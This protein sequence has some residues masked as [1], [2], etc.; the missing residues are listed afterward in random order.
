ARR[1]CT[2]A[3]DQRGRYLHGDLDGGFRYARIDPRSQK[4]VS[5]MTFAQSTGSTKAL[6]TLTG[7]RFASFVLCTFL[8]SVSAARA[9][10]AA[11]FDAAAV[12]RA[13]ADFVERMV[14]KHGFERAEVAATLAD[15]TIS[16][17][18]LE[19]IARPAE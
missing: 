6:H 18:I 9:D 10:D 11:G 13:R 1:R 4:V 15:V 17:Q 7:F 2:A 14:S 12:D 3:A 8:A 19:T 5:R 16:T